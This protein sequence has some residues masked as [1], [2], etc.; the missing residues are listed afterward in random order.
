MLTTCACCAHATV[1]L[2]VAFKRELAQQL[3]GGRPRRQFDKPWTGE[4][5]ENHHSSC[6]KKKARQQLVREKRELVARAEAAGKRELAAAR[7]GETWTS[8][9]ERFP[10]TLCAAAKEKEN[11]HSSCWKKK[12]RQQLVREK[13]ELVARA[14]AAGKRE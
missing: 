9:D 5:E 1:A 8:L 3:F 2:A 6:W 4:E 11:Y 13:K 14:G 7:L 12:A 10:G